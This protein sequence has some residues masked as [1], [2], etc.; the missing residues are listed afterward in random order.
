MAQFTTE[1]VPR[2]GEIGVTNYL[3]ITGLHIYICFIL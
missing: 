2:L 1:V 3:Y